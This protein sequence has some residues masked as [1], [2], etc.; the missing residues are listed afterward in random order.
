[1]R[2]IMPMMAIAFYATDVCVWCL[3]KPCG[4]EVNLCLWNLRSVF[5]VVGFVVGSAIWRFRW[6]PRIVSVL[7]A[8][9]LRGAA[10]T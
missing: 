10:P 3:F 2:G 6:H 9:P 8:L 7:H 4:A 1:M 5:G